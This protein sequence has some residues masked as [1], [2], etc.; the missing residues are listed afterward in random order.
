[1]KV[2]HE[3]FAVVIRK[4]GVVQ[5]HLGDPGNAAEK[6]VLDA[7]LRGRGHRDGVSIAAEARCDPEYVD[8]FYRELR[9]V[10]HASMVGGTRHAI[11]SLEAGLALPCNTM[12]CEE[13][14]V[15]SA[16]PRLY[17][18][19]RDVSAFLLSPCEARIR[20]GTAWV[21]QLS[22]LNQCSSVCADSLARA[23]LKLAAEARRNRSDGIAWSFCGAKTEQA[24]E[25]ATG[26][27]A[28][29]ALGRRCVACIEAGVDDSLD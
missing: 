25:V 20:P 2:A 12:R 7:R 28:E 23:F 26:R 4:K 19:K 10:S 5:V 24:D 1:M 16:S 22:A 29:T 15:W 14:A 13:P 18:I 21:L 8:L 6:N 9:S 3:L 11:P 27:A 17:R